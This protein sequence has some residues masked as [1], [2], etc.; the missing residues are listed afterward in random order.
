MDVSYHTSFVT[1]VQRVAAHK[2]MLVIKRTSFGHFEREVTGAMGAGPALWVS[3][4]QL[5]YLG[6]SHGHLWVGDPGRG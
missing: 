1:G 3:V 5:T 6:P 4:R 2:Y